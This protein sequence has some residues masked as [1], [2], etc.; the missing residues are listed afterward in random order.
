[1]ALVQYCNY[2]V[3]AN[4]GPC[5]AV[6]AATHTEPCLPSTPRLSHALA[7]H[8]SP[9][10]QCT[11]AATAAG[12]A[13][14]AS[15]VQ[16]S[17]RNPQAQQQTLQPNRKVTR[18]AVGTLHVSRSMHRHNCLQPCRNAAAAARSVVPDMATDRQ[19]PPTA[20][21]FIQVHSKK[22]KSTTPTELL[23]WHGPW[24]AAAQQP[25]PS[26]CAGQHTGNAA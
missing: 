17:T 11:R 24:P 12:Q 4:A 16:Q 7:C 14:A 25:R 2:N 1:M 22:R 9:T 3:K 8:H 21:A 19:Q 23:P 10:G 6:Q 13:A 20:A 5:P 15:R 18:P 26:V